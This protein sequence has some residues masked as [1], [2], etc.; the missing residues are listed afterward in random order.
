MVDLIDSFYSKA[1]T[2]IEKTLTKDNKKT[3][4]LC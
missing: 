3:T 1:K 4:L 2:K